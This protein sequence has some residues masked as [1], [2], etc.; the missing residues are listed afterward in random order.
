MMKRLRLLIFLYMMVGSLMIGAMTGAYLQAVNLVIHFFWQI[1][2]RWFIIPKEWQSL[3]ICLPM[4]LVIG[5]V[6]KYLGQ[7]PLTIGQVLGEV[8]T[9]GHFSWHRWWRIL[10]CGLLILG[11]GADV[12]PEASASGLVAGMIYW[13]GYRYKQAMAS[14]EELIGASLRAQLYAVFLR[15]TDLQ[16]KFPPITSYFSGGRAKKASYAIWILCG[17]IGIVLFFMA[18]PQEGVIGIHLPKI[19]WQWQGF[20]VIVPAVIGGWAFGWF[21]AKIG[22]ISE[23]LFGQ[24]S[25]PIIKGLIGGLLLVAGSLLSNDVLFSGEFTIQPFAEHAYHLAPLF[26]IALGLTKALIS[27]VG[28]ALGWRGGTIFPAIFSSLSMGTALAQLLGTMPRLTVTIFVAVAITTIIRQPLLTVV[29]MALL[30]PI[31]F[32]LLIIIVVYLT[33]WIL[34]RAAWLQP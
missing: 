20:L 23:R 18:F 19:D 21:F 22:E 17:F 24:T 34:Q 27:N 5:I 11:A 32:L 26:L 8:R 31:Q 9:S 12:G 2:P 16:K 14:R 6:Q 29:L 30:C 15:P 28:F 10:L 1:L 13:L 3:V 25:L 33:H 4:G 7:Y